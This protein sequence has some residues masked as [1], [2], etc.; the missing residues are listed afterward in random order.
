M[1]SLAGAEIRTEHLDGKVT[2]E[3]QTHLDFRLRLLCWTGSIAL[4]AAAAWGSRA[5]MFPDGISYLD[6]GDAYWRGDWHNALSSYWSPLYS[7]ATGAVIRLIRPSIQ[8][9]YAVVHAVNFLQYVIA[10]LTFSFF[11]DIFVAHY[12]RVRA[13]VASFGQQLP[14]WLLYVTGYAIFLTSSLCLV[15]MSFVSADM[16]VAGII[17]L[18]SAVLVRVLETGGTWKNASLLGIALGLGYYAKTVMLPTAFVF[19]CVFAVLQRK[20]GRSLKPVLLSL[21]IVLL[22]ATP[23]IAAISVTKG[24][25]TFGDSGIFNYIVNV[26]GGQF[27]IPREPERSHP[28]SRLSGPVEA[29]SYATPISGTYP[30]WYDPS[31][32]HAGIKPR[33][34]LRLQLRTIGISMLACGLILFSA[35]LGLHISAAILF[36]YLVSQNASRCLRILLEYWPLWVPAVIS[37]GMYSILIVEPRYLGAQF[38][39]LWMVALASVRLPRTTWTRRIEVAVACSL[40]AIS[41]ALVIRE[42]WRTAHNIALEESDIA[43][44]ECAKVAIALRGSGLQPGEKVALVADWL[45]P[46]RQGA[47]IARLAKLQIIGEARPATF[48]A[49]DDMSRSRVVDAFAEAGASALITRGTPAIAPPGWQRLADTN[50]FLNPIPRRIAQHPEQHP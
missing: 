3:I 9:E 17:F 31:Y 35:F 29:Y 20:R 49:A 38:C 42:S 27:F 22:M 4:G 18:V 48:W 47:Y 40:I 11:L 5:T 43:T 19:V 7:W 16:L 8:N 21:S 46:S 15:S 23:F 36:L 28:V 26:D 32:W 50:Y 45:L 24:R 30:L 41:C 10:L 2:A 6:I 39:I 12:S 1:T 37:V 13:G 44:P 14:I 25:F 33:F 34:S